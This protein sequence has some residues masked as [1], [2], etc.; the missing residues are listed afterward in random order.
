[1]RELINFELHYP[2]IYFP[3]SAATP[4]SP[5]T[6]SIPRRTSQ[7]ISSSHPHARKQS[8]MDSQSMALQDSFGPDQVPPSPALSSATSERSQKD[9]YSLNENEEEE[10]ENLTP[11]GSINNS[12]E[13]FDQDPSGFYEQGRNDTME[14][15]VRDKMTDWSGIGLGSSRDRRSSISSNASSSN[16]TSNSSTSNLPKTKKRSKT[17]PPGTETLLWSFVQLRGTCEVD[18]TLIKGEDFER[19]KKRLA[20]GEGG[21]E[22]EK[23]TNLK[24][25]RK[26]LGGGEF[27]LGDFNNLNIGNHQSRASNDDG[28]GS[29]LKSALWLSSS[30]SQ[31]SRSTSSSSSSN[32]DK[33]HLDDDSTPYSPHASISDFSTSIGSNGTSTTSSN[34]SDKSTA[35]KHKRTGSTMLDNHNRTLT[36]KSFPTFSMPP[37]MIAVDLVLKPGESKSC[38]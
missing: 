11:R 8:I 33:S 26:I 7:P 22:G 35:N 31:N 10:D 37:N 19:L 32:N 4:N 34:A 6:T 2:L 14:S 21:G 9:L 5:S 28:W 25:G 36:S 16:F 38:E 24:G 1:M 17:Q 3:V 15:V 12:R 13:E 18:E 29:Y 27:D 23:G 20:F 30:N